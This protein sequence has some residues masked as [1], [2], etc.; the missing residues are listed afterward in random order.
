MVKY[1]RVKPK[2]DGHLILFKKNGRWKSI[3]SLIKG[4]LLTPTVREKWKG[5]DYEISGKGIKISDAFDLI[6]TPRSNTY[7]SFGARMVRDESKIK[8]VQ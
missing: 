4:E 8:K 7:T 5:S 1:Y 6:D 2:F 3:Y